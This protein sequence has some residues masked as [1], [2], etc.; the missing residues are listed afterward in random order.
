M[1]LFDVDKIGP[2][3]NTPSPNTHDTI[4]EGAVTAHGTNSVNYTTDAT[5]SGSGPKIYGGIDRLIKSGVATVVIPNGN[6]G[7]ITLTT[8]TV[9]HNLGYAPKAV[10]VL[11]NSQINGGGAYNIQLPAPLSL[12]DNTGA[13]GGAP[14]YLGFVSYMGYATDGTNFYV[15]TYSSG[16]MVGTT[17][18]VTYYLYQQTAQ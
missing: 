10:A 9:A 8:T 11:N 13:T 12:G 17:Y 16:G 3:R 14:E 15:L 5:V 4:L 7:H 18:L 2:K 6:P 1:S